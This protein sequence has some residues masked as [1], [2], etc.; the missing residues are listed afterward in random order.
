TFLLKFDSVFINL[1][2][3]REVAYI[4][5]SSSRVKLFFAYSF[6]NLSLP[7]QCPSRFALACSRSVDAH[8]RE[9]EKSGNPFFDVFF[10]SLSFSTNLA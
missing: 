10:R 8:Y 9:S 5:L 7:I 2:R 1:G 4:T 3:C 6:Q